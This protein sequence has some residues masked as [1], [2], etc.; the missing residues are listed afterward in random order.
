MDMFMEHLDADTDTP[1]V[2]SEHGN[3]KERSG[4]KPKHQWRKTVKQ[5]QTQRIARKVAAD[6]TV[7]DGDTERVTIEDGSLGAVDEHAEE[8][9]HTQHLIDGPF[10]DEEL[11]G[12]VTGAVEGGAEQGEEVAFELVRCGAGVACYVV[13]GDEDADSADGDQNAHD[14]GDVV[15]HMEEEEGQDDHDGYGP[16]VDELGAEHVGV[17]VGEDDEVVTFDVAEG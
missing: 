14:L 11:L 5:E 15:A 17:A 6:F 10:A 13:G 9:H 2:H 12:R 3:V 7:P 16:E 1:E 4:R 8:G